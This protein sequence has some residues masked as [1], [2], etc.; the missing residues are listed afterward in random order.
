MSV[1]IGATAPNKRIIKYRLD[2]FSYDETLP[3]SNKTLLI[4]CLRKQ[5]KG[6]ASV[7]SYTNATRI[8]GCQSMQAGLA[9]LDLWVTG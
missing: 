7:F 9:A 4:P 1:R 2:F 6:N 5:Q 3:K 8:C